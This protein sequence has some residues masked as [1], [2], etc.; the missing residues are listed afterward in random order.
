MYDLYNCT[1]PKCI[2]GPLPVNCTTDLMLSGDSSIYCASYCVERDQYLAVAGRGAWFLSKLFAICDL[3]FGVLDI[4]DYIY[5]S[6]LRTI[7]NLMICTC[8]CKSGEKYIHEHTIILGGWHD[9]DM[10]LAGNTNCSKAAQKYTPTS[11]GMKCFAVSL[12]E[13]RLQM[14]IWAMSAAPLFMSTHVPSIPAASRAILLN[15][16]ALAINSDVLGRMPFRYSLDATGTGTGAGAG[17]QLWRKELVGGEVAVA[18]ANMG[19]QPLRAGLSLDLLEA[20]FSS[21]TRVAVFD[22]F[23]EKELGWHTGS[24]ETV[25]PIPTHGVLL[26]RLSYSPQYGGTFA[27]TREL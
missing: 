22:V 27:H 19:D 18:V 14:A 11:T 24:F 5:I 2:E 25:E 9:P 13:Q 1:Q 16:G 4:L 6:I 10:L 7:R 8:T 15:K 12:D 3:R 20:G 26:L 23:S 21:Y 17:A